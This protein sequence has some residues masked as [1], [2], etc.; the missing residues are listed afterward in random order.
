MEGRR[1][2]GHP[3]AEFEEVL[4]IRPNNVKARQALETLTE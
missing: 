2:R 3:E 1:D 4:K